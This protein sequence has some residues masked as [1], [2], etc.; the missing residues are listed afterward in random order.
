MDFIGIATVLV[1][2]V[3]VYFGFMQ[4]VRMDHDRN[5]RLAEDEREQIIEHHRITDRSITVA[6]ITG[7]E[8]LPEE[9]IREW[10]ASHPPRRR[11]W[12]RRLRG[13]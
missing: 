9:W 11:A 10:R 3:A 8:P 2:V 6:Q 7:L 1:A 5:E 13:R 12:W 4:I